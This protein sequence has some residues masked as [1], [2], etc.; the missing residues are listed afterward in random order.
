[1]A[2]L[3]MTYA[4]AHAAAMDAANRRM[5][6]HGRAAWDEDDYEESRLTMDRLMQRCA[7]P[8]EYARY[9]GHEPD[10]R[11]AEVAR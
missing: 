7:D 2:R 8:D 4:L 3:T 6:Q 11:P 1:M 10:E 5:R 9:W